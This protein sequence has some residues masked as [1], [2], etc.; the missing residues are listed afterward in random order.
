VYVTQPNYQSV[1][2]KA[3]VFGIPVS[4]AFAASALA[5]TK[6]KTLIALLQLIGAACLLVVIFTH[7]SEAFHLFP[8]MGWGQPNSPGHYVDL[9]SAIAGVIFLA[10]GYF[11]RRYLRRKNF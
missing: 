5:F 7:M 8:S 6:E 1:L 3:I 4:I 10:V 2:W 11:S 9:V